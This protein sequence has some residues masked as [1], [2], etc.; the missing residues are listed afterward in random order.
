VK[1]K[2][3]ISADTFPRNYR[4]TLISGEMLRAQQPQFVAPYVLSFSTKI[5]S[6]FISYF[7]NNFR[8]EFDVH[9]DAAVLISIET[10]SF[11]L[12][13]NIQHVDTL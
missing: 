8:N 1:A 12:H 4:L 2:L 5:L 3:K 6:L 9:N 10:D 7:V 13:L 11:S